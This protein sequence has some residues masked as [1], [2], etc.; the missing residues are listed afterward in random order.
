M[1]GLAVGLVIDLF[2]ELLAFGL[3][4]GLYLAS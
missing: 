4:R 1:L 3:L 2:V